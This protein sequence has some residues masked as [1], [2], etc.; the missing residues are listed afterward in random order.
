MT[1]DASSVNGSIVFKLKPY[2][3]YSDEKHFFAWLE[4]IEGVIDVKGTARGLHVSFDAP[5]LS[6]AGAY[7]LIA[8]FSRYGCPLAP[9]R[10]FISPVDS[11]YFE[12]PDSYWFEELYG[13]DP[14]T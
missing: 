6:R 5:L 2:Y 8:L 3:S 7:D 12:S 11:E 9:I 13:N 4:S 1:N 10:P 14:A